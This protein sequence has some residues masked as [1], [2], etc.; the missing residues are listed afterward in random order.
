MELEK[1]ITYEGTVY[2][3]HCDQMGH[4]TD[5][6]HVGKFDEA[7]WNLLASVGLTPT[8]FRDSNRGMVAVEQRLA[9]EKELIAGD[10]IFVRSRVLEAREKAILFVHEMVNAQTLEVAATSYYTAVH[11]DRGTRRACPLP[12][13][14][15]VVL[16]PVN[17]SL[18]PETDGT[19]QSPA[20]ASLG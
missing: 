14:V 9:Y 8:Y 4:M 20:V 16:R 3:W 15:Q 19:N 10:M 13:H 18:R 5:M 11:I 6:W 1:W 17:G 7:S 2:P 12:P